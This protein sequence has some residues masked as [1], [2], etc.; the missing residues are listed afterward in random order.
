MDFCLQALK[1]FPQHKSCTFGALSFL[2]PCH[3]FFKSFNQLYDIV[4]TITDLPRLN[5]RQQQ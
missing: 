1:P 3:F 2:L 4:G 5:N